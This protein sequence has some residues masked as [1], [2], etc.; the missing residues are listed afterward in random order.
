MTFK[1]LISCN[2]YLMKPFY[3]TFEK[4]Q[5]IK[6]FMYKNNI[7]HLLH[8]QLLCFKN[9]LNF[10]LKKMSL[11]SHV[12]LFNFHE[13][14]NAVNAHQKFFDVDGDECL[15]KCK[16]FAHFDVKD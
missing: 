3:S 9:G 10:N 11:L 15:S 8:K 13:R 16:C 5:S 14:K 12:L 2:P 1:P 7:I 6:Y 4:S